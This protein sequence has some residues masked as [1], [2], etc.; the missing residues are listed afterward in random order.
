VTP[1]L[2]RDQ[3]SAVL[4]DPAYRTAAES[5][6]DELDAL[7]GPDSAVARLEELADDDSRATQDQPIRNS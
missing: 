3:V 1:E 2:I 5:L 7:P 6:R 4:A